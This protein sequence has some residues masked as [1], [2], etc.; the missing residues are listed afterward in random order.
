MSIRKLF[1]S[2]AFAFSAAGAAT[3]AHGQG[4]LEKLDKAYRAGPCSDDLKNYCAR[5]Q[6]GEARVADCLAENF[7]TIKPSCRGAITAAR[8]KFDAMA[9]ACKGD[10]EK[11]CKGIAYR[12][13]RVLS[14]LKSHQ[15]NLGP[16]CA[17]AF[18]RVGSDQRV[19][20]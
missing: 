16:A 8:N 1:F 14:C 10:A 11:L 20:E 12:E 9:E 13:G 6:P 18:K 7:R 15:S 3:L 2:M 5:V 19:T 4:N 17:A